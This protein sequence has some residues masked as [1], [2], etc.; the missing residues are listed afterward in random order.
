MYMYPFETKLHEVADLKCDLNSFTE[1]LT[2]GIMKIVY[3]K[4]YTARQY[5]T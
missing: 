5:N 4:L 3:L 2:T 1:S